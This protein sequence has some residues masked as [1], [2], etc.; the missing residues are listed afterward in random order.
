MPYSKNEKGNLLFV[1]TE[2]T[3]MKTKAAAL[4]PKHHHKQQ[5]RWNYE[6]ECLHSPLKK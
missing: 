2:I 3:K 4:K 1:I 6:A 5:E